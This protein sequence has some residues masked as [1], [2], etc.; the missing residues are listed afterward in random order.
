MASDLPAPVPVSDEIIQDL[1]CSICMSLSSD[2]PVITPCQHIFCGGCLSEA[3]SRQQ[4]CPVDRC[5][6]APDQVTSIQEGSLTRRIWSNIR[7]KCGNHTDGC[8][9]V[10][11]VA[12]YRSHLLCCTHNNRQGAASTHELDE[13]LENLSR[14]VTV[15][16]EQTETLHSLL[17]E[18]DDQIET[19]SSSLQRKDNQI[20][21]LRRDAKSLDPKTTGLFWES[22]NYSRFDVVK[23][24]QLISSRL[25]NKPRYIDSNKIFNCV[26]TCFRDWSTGYTDNPKHYF[27]DMRMLLATCLASS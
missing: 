24:S 19:L 11:A 26:Q 3:L 9:W 15:L 16:R 6:V 23:L 20:S 25:E 10:G 2:V 13:E 22:Y 21:Q 7:V 27:L 17:Q 14:N 8:A 12:D 18:K 5:A 4:V 1:V